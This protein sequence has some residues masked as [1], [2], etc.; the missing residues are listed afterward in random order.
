MPINIYG[1]FRTDT[2]LSDNAA[3]YA[4]T[5]AT[6]EI[7]S[8]SQITI[9]DGANAAIIDGDNV[10]NESPNDPTQT[11]LGDAIA[12]DYTITVNDGTTN[13]QVG[14][15][16]LDVNGDGDF[17]FPTGEQGY[18]IAF[19]GGQIPPLNTTLTLGAVTDNGPSIPVTTVVPCFTEGTMIATQEG[20]RL[21]ES[22]SVG[23]G[24]LTADHGVRPIRW[25]GRRVLDRADLAANPKLRPI[26]I[27]KDA[28]GPGKP[29]RDLLVSPQH[30]MLIRSEIAVRMF[31]AAEILVPAC[32]LVG[33]PGVSVAEDVESVV[34]IHLL[35]DR[36]EVVFAEDTPS[37]SLYTGAEAL[38]AVGDAAQEEILTLFPELSRPG[39]VAEPA[40]LIVQKR[41]RIDRLVERH[42]A[43]EKVFVI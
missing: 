23:D 25:I 35:F 28:L 6:F 16:D 39:H 41:P 8:Y 20:E 36:H 27:A 15:L 32:K 42:L 31:D 19:I 17:D 11:Y 1:A 33:I 37:E 14:F 22:L 5:G 10:S 4:T 29:A 2:T 24:V 40:R 18:F 7:S 3:T 34:Y 43:N 12:W 21:I 13:Y 26:R 38:K 30:R 9:S